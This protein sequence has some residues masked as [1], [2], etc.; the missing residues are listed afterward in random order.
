MVEVDVDVV[1]VAESVDILKS[2]QHA[3][4]DHCS[5]GGQDGDRF[6]ERNRR[7]GRSV[8]LVAAYTSAIRLFCIG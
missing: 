5:D 8:Q 2:R 3:R 7:R 1:N 4:S 6:D